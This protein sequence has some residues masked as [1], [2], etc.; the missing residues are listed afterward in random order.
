MDFSVIE[1]YG[2][3]TFSCQQEQIISY[4]G[5]ILQVSAD[6]GPKGPS[7]SSKHYHLSGSSVKEV[8]GVKW[9]FF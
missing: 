5:N 7:V 9:L 6:P 3:R 8:R 1:G 2:Q 4:C